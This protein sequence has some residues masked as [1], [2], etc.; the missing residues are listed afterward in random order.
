M[1]MSIRHWTIERQFYFQVAAASD[2]D[3]SKKRQRADDGSLSDQPPIV[4]LVIGAGTETKVTNLDSGWSTTVP[5]KNGMFE[6]KDNNAVTQGRYSAEI[7][8]V[9]GSQKTLIKTKYFNKI[10]MNGYATLIFAG[11]VASQKQP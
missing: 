11:D 5:I 2:A 10:K 6:V 9:N 1:R 3:R 4:G 8:K 7:Y